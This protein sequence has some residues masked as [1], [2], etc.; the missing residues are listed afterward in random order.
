M[1]AF[2]ALT[3]KQAGESKGFLGIAAIALFG[4]SWLTVFITARIEA[5]MRTAEDAGLRMPRMLRGMGGAAMDFST[6]AIETAWWNH[7]FVVLLVI[8]W[9][10]A[11]GSLPVAGELERGTLDLT[12]S[13]PIS[14]FAY[15]LSNVCVAVLGLLVLAAALVAGNRVGSQY[16]VVATPPSVWILTRPALNLAALGLAIY[17]VT[18]FLGALDV[19]R[20]RPNMIAS[21]F[22]LGSFILL[23]IV[24]A[25]SLEEWKWL[26]R[27]SIFKAYNPVEAAVKGEHV[28]FNAGV[29]AAIGL[30]GIT[31]A[32]IQFLRRDLPAGGG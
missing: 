19:V 13:R 20:W 6:A 3:R 15:L 1:T 24:Q 2:V 18:L 16:N 11:R 12:L 4:I 26:E 17:G 32:F 21:I 31:L 30:G 14:R 8:S 22:T 29:L 10:I 9:A 23:A 5:R 7:P 25:P 27:Y 28:A